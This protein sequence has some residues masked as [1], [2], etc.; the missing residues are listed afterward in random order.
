MAMDNSV[1]CPSDRR[2]ISVEEYIESFGFSP[3]ELNRK[4]MREVQKEVAAINKGQVILDGVL[5][6]K[7]KNVIWTTTSI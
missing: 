2:T 1:K 7:I 5:A 4:E 6:F 3:S